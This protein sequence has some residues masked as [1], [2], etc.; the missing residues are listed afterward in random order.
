MK[1]F[2]FGGL[3]SKLKRRLRKKHTRIQAMTFEAECR[4]EAGQSDKVAVND[5]V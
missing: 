3:K 5:H 4:Q 1:L 2:Q